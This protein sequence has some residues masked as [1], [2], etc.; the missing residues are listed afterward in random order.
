MTNGVRCPLQC[1]QCC[2]YW[3][4][5]PELVTDAVMKP[6]AVECPHLTDRGCGLQRKDRP[7]ECVDYLCGVA[8]AV[9]DQRISRAEGFRLKELYCTELPYLLPSRKSA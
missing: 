3:R 6:N 9:I 8:C 2:D 4:D 1:G 5:V 7:E